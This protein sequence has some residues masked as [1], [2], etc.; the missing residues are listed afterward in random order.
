MEVRKPESCQWSHWKWG[1]RLRQYG[2]DSV[3]SWLVAGAC[4]LASCFAMSVRRSSGLL[5]VAIQET[6]LT[7]KSDGSWPIMVMGAV[8]YLSGLITGPM[9]HKFTARPVIIAG[10]ATSSI[11]AIISYIAPSID[12]MTFTLGVVH[13]IG[14]GM[15]FIVAPTIINEHFD[16]RKGLAMGLNYTGVTM[17]LFVFPKLLEYLT[18]LYGLRGSLLIFGAVLMNGL[19][20]SLFTRTPKWIN[21]RTENQGIAEN[22]ST[23]RNEKA[24]RTLQYGLSVLKHPTFYLIMYSFNAY[25]LVFEC[26]ITLFVDFAIDRGVPVSSAVTISSMG[27]IAEIAGRFIIP[28]AVDRGLL[29]NKAVMVLLLSAEGII[30]ILLPVISNHVQI[31]A[32][33]LVIAFLVGT[34]MVVFP[35]ILASYFGQERLSMSFGMVIATSGMLSFAKPSLV[36]YFRDRVGAYDWLFVICGTLNL[37]GTAVW[38]L[39]ITLEARHKKNLKIQSADHTSKAADF[40]EIQNANKN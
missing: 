2:P 5:F 21:T 14:G 7:N 39:V 11:G 6:F 32:A 8:M 18:K 3:H 31:F 27:A 20:F 28:A 40:M 10:A 16:K 36:G 13:A 15:V 12:V 19:A 22:S 29:G 26:Y 30:L 4:A 17:G 23:S 37:V 24:E 1:T 38:A 9:A 34:G 33:D 25:S 35:M